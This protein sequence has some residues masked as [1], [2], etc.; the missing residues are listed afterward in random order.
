[1]QQ[2]QK[3]FH[4]PYEQ[5]SLETSKFV[6]RFIEYASNS[7]N[8]DVCSWSIDNSAIVIHDDKEFDKVVLPTLG[9]KQNR[10]KFIT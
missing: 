7:K 1:M 8:S 9:W 3:A 10:N 5:C 6:F 4:N 2:H